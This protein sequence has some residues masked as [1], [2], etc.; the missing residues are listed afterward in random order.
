MEMVG[1]PQQYGF[2]NFLPKA[3]REQFVVKYPGLSKNPSYWRMFIFLLSPVTTEGK[4]KIVSAKL[5]AAIEDKFAQ[6]MSR[7]YNAK[8]FLEQ[9]KRDVLPG[10]EYEEAHHIN[11]IARTVKTTGI[12]QCDHDAWND[13]MS[14]KI[15]AY[16]TS[17]YRT[18]CRNNPVVYAETG[19]LLTRKRQKATIISNANAFIECA[20]LSSVSEETIKMME[21]HAA[22]PLELYTRRAKKNFSK[23]VHAFQQLKP[24]QQ[25]RAQLHRL[26]FDNVKPI[27]RHAPN[28]QRLVPGTFP[29]WTSAK[30]ELTHAFFAGDVN[31]DLTY[32]H[33]AIGAHRWQD[34]IMIKLLSRLQAKKQSF[35]Q[36]LAKRTKCPRPLAEVKESFKKA[37]YALF[38][39]AGAKRLKLI[40][41]DQYS[42]FS[43]LKLMK[44]IKHHRD[45]EIRL[46]ADNKFAKTQLP[47]AECK[48][49]ARSQMALT[50]QEYELAL[51]Y[52]IYELAYQELQKSHPEFRIMLYSYD[53]VCI[54]IRYARTTKKQ[55]QNR[56]SVINKIARA[57]FDKAADYGSEPHITDPVN[58][59]LDECNDPPYEAILTWLSHEEL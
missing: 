36:W 39:G 52:P 56:A 21:Y 14:S 3:L 8:R 49:F 11:K 4:P 9:F 13:F 10:F 34:P 23:I 55:L 54:S 5:C 41:G 31:L 24:R 15:A 29:H 27:Y 22:T 53:G 16:G 42:S 17:D 46:I 7:N 44:R 30:R 32:A 35:W 57:I 18:F 47:Y 25:Q 48:A 51:I 26:L 38:N 28:T 12:E 2:Y 33:L 6:L 58:Y 40:L 20:R 1:I 37:L 50:L 45:R 43:N 19:L 59:Y